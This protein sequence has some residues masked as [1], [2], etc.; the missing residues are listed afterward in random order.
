[1][2]PIT[3]LRQEAAIPRS[4]IPAR[5]E[6]RFIALDLLWCDSKDL[7]YSPMVERKQRLHSLVPQQGEGLLYCDHGCCGLGLHRELRPCVGKAIP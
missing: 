7:R 2:D 1:V 4:P 3:A 5:G 6:P